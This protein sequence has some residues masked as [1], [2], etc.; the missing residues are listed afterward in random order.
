MLLEYLR[1]SKRVRG[2]GVDYETA[3]ATSCIA[4]D[5]AVYQEDI[6]RAL[7][8]LADD[9]FDWVI[10]SRM[11][12]ELPEPGS[13]ILEALRVGK[14]VALSF[15]NYGYWRNRIHFLGKGVRVKNDVYPDNWEKSD[16]R[17]HFSISEF[18]NFCKNRQGGQRPFEIGRKVYH[19]GDW[20]KTCSVLP[21][22]R[23]G[24]AIYEL[25][26]K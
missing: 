12:E 22:L 23:A 25:T 19:Q 26:K 20:L 18:E 8:N 13:V 5:V 7:K 6:R 4:R 15:V 14:R 24:L 2:L 16:L 3:K 9:S 21:N 11:I 17:N 1:D 10:F